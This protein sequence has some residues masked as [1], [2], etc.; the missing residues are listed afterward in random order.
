MHKWWLILSWFLIFVSISI[1]Q[2]S[3][4]VKAQEFTE[5]PYVF[6]IEAERCLHEPESVTTDDRPIRRQ[7]GFRVKGVAGII[8]ALHGIVDC[9]LISA[10]SES[11]EGE[12]FGDLEIIAVDI[13]RDVA[14]LLPRGI[15]TGTVTAMIQVGFEVAADNHTTDYT[16][17]HL[18]GHPYGAR[19]QYTTEQIKLRKTSTDTLALLLSSSLTAKLRLR[20]SP[21]PDLDVL[22]IEGNLVPGHSGAP[23]INARGQVVGVG[24]GGL[25][26]EISWLIPWHKIQWQNYDVVWSRIN[27][28]RKQDPSDI[29]FDVVDT[30]STS[31]D[32][33]VYSGRVLDD[34]GKFVTRAHVVLDLGSE[35]H[36]VYSDSEGKFAI[37][38]E[39]NRP[40]QGRIY[41][42]AEGY[43]PQEHLVNLSVAQRQS[44]EFALSRTGL[45]AL[46]CAFG[47][48]IINANQ[49]P[50]RGAH[51]RIGY[52]LDVLEGYT[53]SDG[54]YWGELPCDKRSPR[55]DVEV[56]APSYAPIEKSYPLYNTLIKIQLPSL[57]TLS[58]TLVITRTTM[59]APQPTATTTPQ[60]PR[61]LFR[62]D[63]E[64]GIQPAWRQAEAI[65]IRNGKLTLNYHDETDWLQGYILSE[66]SDWHTYRLLVDLNQQRFLNDEIQ[67]ETHLFVHYQ[68]EN[69]FLVLVFSDAFAQRAPTWFAVVDGMWMEHKFAPSFDPNKSQIQIK[70]E[71]NNDTIITYF[72]D[73]VI[74]LWAETP[75]TAGVVGILL[76]AKGIEPQ[77]VDNFVIEDMNSVSSS[78]TVTVAMPPEADFPLPT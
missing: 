28:L 66:A 43:S 8:T 62:D 30:L 14:T 31:S 5:S 29:F 67:R 3:A 2:N 64:N 44:Q 33:V 18:I 39:A 10:V 68:D 54:E 56:S 37:T 12:A 65:T 35:S 58:S 41:I 51:V 49:E 73:K 19:A 34:Q 70:V 32:Y 36:L 48:R 21:N 1:F 69:N 52:R 9:E 63:F 17:L 38:V 46:Y 61:I 74:D 23:V 13:D 45:N 72:D 57:E 16:V 24:N 25:G 26:D 7:T 40:T 4:I 47:F 75:F 55:V 78:P 53:N 20:N 42:Q 15:S 77:W 6:M 59:P 60:P 22:S 71:V 76:K 50:I 11:K 27:Q